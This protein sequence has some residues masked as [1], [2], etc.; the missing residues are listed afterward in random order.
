MTKKINPTAAATARSLR[1]RVSKLLF[2]AHLHMMGKPGLPQA[3]QLANV[4]A[5]VKL[6][7]EA[8]V[9][10]GNLRELIQSRI[11]AF[12]EIATQ[13]SPTV[14]LPADVI[15]VAFQDIV[16]SESIGE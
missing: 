8:L 11:D 6:A 3:T 1:H 4:D 13:E 9:E 7:Q 16:K 15:D 5:A 12:A 2:V 10:L 14:D